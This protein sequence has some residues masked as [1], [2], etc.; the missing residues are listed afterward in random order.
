MPAPER[1]TVP[2]F[3]SDGQRRLRRYSE[4]AAEHLEGLSLVTVKRNRRGL[5]LAIHFRDKFGGS[6]LRATAKAGQRYSFQERISE[7]HRAWAH[8]EIKGDVTYFVQVL[9]DQIK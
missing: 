5:I 9:I 8:A 7:R 1:R 4:R 2:A 3:S 6:P